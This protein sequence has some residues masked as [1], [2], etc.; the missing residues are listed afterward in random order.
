LRDQGRVFAI[1]G[2]AFPTA[3]DIKRCRQ[4]NGLV[5]AAQTSGS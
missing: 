4:I 5:P 1:K 2:E 3:C